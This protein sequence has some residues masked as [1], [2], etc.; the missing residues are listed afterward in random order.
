M[1]ARLEG[2][3]NNTAS[4]W[5]NTN[6][7]ITSQP[8]LAASQRPPDNI[9]LIGIGVMPHSSIDIETKAVATYDELAKRNQQNAACMKVK[10]PQEILNMND[11]GEYQCGWYYNK[12]TQSGQGFLSNRK[13][14][15]DMLTVKPTIIPTYTAAYFGSDGTPTSMQAAQ[16]QY[17]IDRCSQVPSCSQIGKYP[18]C[19]Y[20][21]TSLKGIPINPDNSPKYPRNVMS[22]CYQANIITNSTKCPVPPP[23]PVLTSKNASGITYPKIVSN[24]QAE[25]NG[26]LSGACLQLALVKPTNVQDPDSG[27]KPQGA[28]Y[29]ALN[30]FSSTA[31]PAS[32]QKNNINIGTY[33]N[34]K[35]NFDLNKF[36][37]APTME[38]AQ[39]QAIALSTDSKRA[40]EAAK[41]NREG[42]TKANTLAIDLCK[43]EGYFRDQYDFCTDLLP[44]TTVPTVGWDLGCLQKAFLKTFKIETPPSGNL[45]PRTKGDCAHMYYNNTKAT[46]GAVTDYMKSI[47]DNMYNGG[48]MYDNPCGEKSEPIVGEA[49]YVSIPFQIQLTNYP[50]YRLRW[51]GK[52]DNALWPSNFFNSDNDFV[53][54]PSTI[55]PKAIQITPKNW[56]PT[57]V[58]RH[59]SFQLHTDVQNKADQLL[60][61]DSS[62]YVRPGNTGASKTVS[63]ESVNFPGYFLR[64]AGLCY[65]NRS[66]GSELFKM[67]STFFIVDPTNNDY[68]DFKWFTPR[69]TSVGVKNYPGQQS[70]INQ[71]IGTIVDPALTT[72][73]EGFESQHKQGVELLALQPIHGIHTITSHISVPSLKHV[74]VGGLSLVYT[75]ANYVS[76]RDQT[77]IATHSVFP[78]NTLDAMINGYLKDKPNALD[79]FVLSARQP[80]LVKTLWKS[81]GHPGSEYSWTVKPDLVSYV[82]LRPEEPFLRFEP[83]SDP[84]HTGNKYIFTEVRM[85]EIANVQL[86]G[87]LPEFHTSGI[88]LLKAPGTHGFVHLSSSQF[89]IPY[90]DLTLCQQA[91]FCFSVAQ[92]P[93]ST[94]RNPST[95]LRLCNRTDQ[96]MMNG[97]NCAVYGSTNSTISFVITTPGKST[98]PV[99]LTVDKWYTLTLNKET[100]RL[101]SI[102]TH[103]NTSSLVSTILL[104][105][106]TPIQKSTSRIGPLIQIGD[107]ST[108]LR[109]NVAW[110]H[111]Y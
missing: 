60:Q 93:S 80:N 70:A 63:F 90:V 16:E 33:L 92:I 51:I 88:S 103:T 96:A 37:M 48:P 104:T 94:A 36:V 24:C 58:V 46:W 110:L 30:G 76:P 49:D 71:G 9:N 22:A 25:P 40:S 59:R 47:Y 89:N 11:K 100:A 68:K 81:N 4:D 102:N 14:P 67:D 87:P 38:D 35:P 82:P 10:E 1:F 66:D 98:S 69:T 18:G 61:K 83:F 19:G 55:D 108:S 32:L 72:Y 17:D 91:T 65:I 5:K 3:I 52:A 26:R 8:L 73:A 56:N 111:L 64:H 2:Y 39:S 99:S 79:R 77:V 107:A 44:T 50:L 101:S 7:I 105:H 57:S 6:T 27:C 106:T 28:L 29:T 34:L 20:C 109:L 95:V 31:D 42:Q 97:Y 41:A 15:L 54:R 21:S 23:V 13:G 12:N 86:G 45:Y 78:G 62:F 53:W 43:T 84:V 75:L 74:N 85:P